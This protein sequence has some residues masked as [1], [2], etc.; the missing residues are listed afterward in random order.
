MENTAGKWFSGKVPNR[1]LY[2]AGI[3]L[4]FLVCSAHQPIPFPGKQDMQ[5]DYLATIS[6]DPAGPGQTIPT[7][8]LGV[9]HNWDQAQ[10]LI[11]DPQVGTNPIY[12][13]LLSN[14]LSFGGSH[15]VLRIRSGSRATDKPARTGALAQ[16]FQDLSNPEPKISYILGINTESSDV[17]LGSRQTQAYLSELPAGSVSA[18]EISHEPD[19]WIRLKY[20]PENYRFPDYV[21]ELQKTADE[22]RTAVPGAP[23]FM[24]PSL[25]RF[26]GEAVS[27][28]GTLADFRKL[29]QM[30]GLSMI[31]QHSYSTSGTACGGNPKPGI[32]MQPAATTEDP[33]LSAPLIKMARQ[34][35]K[36]FRITEMN[37]VKCAEPGISNAFESALWAADI[38]FEYAK[39]GASG[40]NI[41]INNWNSVHGWD[42]NSAF[43]FNVPE[44]QYRSA[45]TIPPPDDHTFPS[46]YSIKAVMP[47]YYGMLLFAEAAPAQTSLLPLEL[48]TDANFKAWATLNEKTGELKIVLINKEQNLLGKVRLSV[49]GYTAAKVKRLMAPSFRSQAGITYGGQTFDGSTDGKP[50][51]KPETEIIKSTN[52]AFEVPVG[53]ATAILI[54][55]KK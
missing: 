9:S 15:L 39:A 14:L 33:K 12:R 36:P 41:H 24:G 13:Q 45:N 32:L 51:G 35:N 18:I 30:P 44:A 43:L 54:T 48:K 10:L 20:R 11:G 46:E 16:L 22:I 2:T 28:F 53:P 40:V 17:S 52:N 7:G 29:V 23:R 37:A 4:A 42:A 27:Q 26:P 3:A 1:M 25:A 49:P 5:P 55:L 21:A 34:A 19:T 31:S 50:V 47:L 6:V 38:L 8:F